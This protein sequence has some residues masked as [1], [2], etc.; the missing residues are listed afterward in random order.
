MD[1]CSSPYGMVDKK[2]ISASDSNIHGEYYGAYSSCV[3]RRL[4]FRIIGH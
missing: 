4:H 1:E 2:K 3:G